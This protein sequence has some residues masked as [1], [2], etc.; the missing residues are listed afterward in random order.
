MVYPLG[1]QAVDQLADF[2]IGLPRDAGANNGFHLIV[3]P[4]FC[5]LPDGY[6][7]AERSFFHWPTQSRT[8]RNLQG[9]SFPAIFSAASSMLVQVLKLASSQAKTSCFM[10][11]F[12]L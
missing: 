9:T 2:T 4:G 12:S 6:G 1:M 7:P 10:A 11:R 5:T 3:R 8:V